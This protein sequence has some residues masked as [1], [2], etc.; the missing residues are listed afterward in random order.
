MMTLLIITTV[1]ICCAVPSCIQESPVRSVMGQSQ[2][3]LS[4][5]PNGSLTLLPLIKDLP[6][7][8]A[9]PACHQEIAPPHFA[10]YYKS[11]FIDFTAIF[12]HL[13]LKLPS[14]FVFPQIFGLVDN[15]WNFITSLQVKFHSQTLAR[16]ASLPMPLFRGMSICLA[17]CSGLPVILF[18]CFVFPVYLVTFLCLTFVLSKFRIF[19]VKIRLFSSR[20]SIPSWIA[21]SGV[22]AHQFHPDLMVFRVN[23]TCKFYVKFDK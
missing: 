18:V 22:K 20:T 10:I 19:N 8:V 23:P 9:K 11:I 2:S 21:R 5:Q 12:S 15:I 1:F 3:V 13:S 14:S 7:C 16:L 6:A 17:V 4:V